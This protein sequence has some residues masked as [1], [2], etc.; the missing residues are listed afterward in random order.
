M[1]YG[2]ALTAMCNFYPEIFG[3]NFVMHSFLCDYVK[4]NV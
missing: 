2:E 4:Y 3:L 1:F